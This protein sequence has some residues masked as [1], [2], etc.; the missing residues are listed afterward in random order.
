MCDSSNINKHNST[1]TLF[2]Q[3]LID[4]TIKLLKGTQCYMMFSY[5]VIW[6]WTYSQVKMEDNKSSYNLIP[7]WWVVSLSFI[8]SSNSGGVNFFLWSRRDWTSPRFLS[9]WWI[10]DKGERSSVTRSEYIDEARPDPYENKTQRQPL[11]CS[12]GRLQEKIH[13]LKQEILKINKLLDNI[14]MWLNVH[15]Y[16]EI[17]RINKLLD[18]IIM[19]LNIHQYILKHKVNAFLYVLILIQC[20]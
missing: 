11:S 6:E 12:T 3:Y 9:S 10:D 16:K 20:I 8:N 17:F 15:R 7:L 18:Y 2:K 4:H 1:Y 13:W 19:Q 14:I 5:F